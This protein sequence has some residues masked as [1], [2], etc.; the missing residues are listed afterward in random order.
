M[1]TVHQMR[2]EVRWKSYMMRVLRNNK[3]ICGT[4]GFGARSGKVMMSKDGDVM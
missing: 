3:R 4:G 2:T 1:F